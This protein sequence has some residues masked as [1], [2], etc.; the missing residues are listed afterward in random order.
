MHIDPEHPKRAQWVTYLSMQAMEKLGNVPLLGIVYRFLQHMGLWI[1]MQEHEVMAMDEWHN[2]GPQDLIT[3]SLCIQIT[4]DKMQLCSLSV[5][6]A[7]PFHNPTVTMGYSLHSVGISKSIANT[8]SYMWSTVVRPVG[9]TAKFSKMTLEAAYSR[10]MHIQ[11][12]ATA[13]VDIPVV[14]MPIAH[15]LKT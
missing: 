8:T 14:S 2:N 15:S 3:V 9:C 10:A 12:L 5:A 4:I 6:C 1:I 7:C 11:F 13:M